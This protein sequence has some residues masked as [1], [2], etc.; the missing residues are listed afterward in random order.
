MYCVSKVVYK[1]RD[2]E[3]TLA[4]RT[5]L[6]RSRLVSLCWCNDD[7]EARVGFNGYR[8]ASFRSHKSS[9]GQIS[10]GDHRRRSAHNSL[11]LLNV[12]G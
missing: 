7:D 1:H 4:S 9:S 3:G 12:T 6:F 11:F 10:T 2:R 5:F 8:E